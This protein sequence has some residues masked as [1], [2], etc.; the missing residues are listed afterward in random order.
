MKKMHLQSVHE[1]RLHQALSCHNEKLPDYL[2]NHEHCHE[3]A[4]QHGL[5]DG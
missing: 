5:Q 4:A 3:W 2:Q 1:L